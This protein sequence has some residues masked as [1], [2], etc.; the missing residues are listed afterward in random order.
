[1]KSGI[2][3]AMFTSARHCHVKL[4]QVSNL[5]LEDPF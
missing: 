1:M 3:I 5:F 4:I 2:F